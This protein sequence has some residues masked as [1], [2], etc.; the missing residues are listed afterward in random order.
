MLT[1]PLFQVYALVRSKV[2]SFVKDRAFTADIKNVQ[3]MIAENQIWE[4]VSKYLDS[5]PLFG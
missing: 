5:D 1:N 4:V 2:P 3:K